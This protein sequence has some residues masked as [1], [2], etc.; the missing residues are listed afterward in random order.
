[1][2][3]KTPQSM[4]FVQLSGKISTIIVDSTDTIRL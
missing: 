1:M 2:D 4:D 3:A